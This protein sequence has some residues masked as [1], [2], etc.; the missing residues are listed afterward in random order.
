MIFVSSVVGYI[1]FSYLMIK[2]KVI[3]TEENNLIIFIKYVYFF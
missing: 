3:V 2:E 1:D